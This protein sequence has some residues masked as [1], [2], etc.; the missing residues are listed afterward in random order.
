MSN[1]RLPVTAFASFIFFV[2]AIACS[3][4][5]NSSSSHKPSSPGPG[6]AQPAAPVEPS[7]RVTADQ[8][9]A[10]YKA[11][12]V[13]AD[14]LYKGRLVEVTGVVGNVGKDILG[15]AYVT[16]R[17][18]EDFE[19]ASVQCVPKPRWN[20]YDLQP[21]YT[22][23]IT[24]VCAGK[25]INVVL[26][27]CD[28]ATK[29]HAAEKSH[30]ESPQDA[31]KRIAAENAAQAERAEKQRLAEAEALRIARQR[32]AAKRDAQLAANAAA[33]ARENEIA[34]LKAN[35][36][37]DANLR[38]AK[39]LLDRR[40]TVKAKQRLA[41]IVKEFSETKAAKEAAALLKDLAD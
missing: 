20:L 1:F 8:L 24:G 35:V 26:K 11:N 34:S 30:A 15:D 3:G 38:Y 21:G 39:K 9:I 17:A 40:E 19:F 7:Q 41:E 16:L 37:A 36:S 31:A 14:K 32:E 2:A 25:F 29:E 27:D 10:E 12:E 6:P 23:T 18:S 33:I 13:R 28:F 22:C 5:G 4:G